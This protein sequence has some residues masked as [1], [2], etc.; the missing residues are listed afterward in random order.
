M[1]PTLPSR[2]LLE[3]LLMAVSVVDLRP[4]HSD[5]FC[6]WA[7]EQLLGYSPQHIPTVEDWARLAYTPHRNEV[8]DC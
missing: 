6:N 1:N 8:F 3:R 4:G 7:F 5:L 2:K